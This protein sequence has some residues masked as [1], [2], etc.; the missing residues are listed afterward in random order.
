MTLKTA[1]RTTTSW[2]C[3]RTKWL[4]PKI[5][6]KITMM[7]ASCQKSLSWLSLRRGN[8]TGSKMTNV[9]MVQTTYT[10]KGWL[11]AQWASENIDKPIFYKILLKILAAH[12]A[13]FIVDLAHGVTLQRWLYYVCVIGRQELIQKSIL[14]SMEKVP[15][16]LMAFS[17]SSEVVRSFGAC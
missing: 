6:Q 15:L 2:H 17:S 10:R 16:T 7:T 14:K 9:Q 4:A 5:P 12:C 13:L 3:I 8:T 1:I 11:R